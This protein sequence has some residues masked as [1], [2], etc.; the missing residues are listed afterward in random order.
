MTI[1]VH[2]YTTKTLIVLKKETYVRSYDILQKD[3]TIC[4][5]L[6]KIDK[7]IQQHDA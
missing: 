3:K 2:I 5:L 4:G 7:I 6:Q 1:H